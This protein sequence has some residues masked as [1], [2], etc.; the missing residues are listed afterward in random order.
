MM[1]CDDPSAAIVK[2]F[3]SSL[4]WFFGQIRPIFAITILSLIG[5][6]LYTI[7]LLDFSSE[8]Q[9][10]FGHSGHAKPLPFTPHASSIALVSVEWKPTFWSKCSENTGILTKN[11]RFIGYSRH[12]PILETAH[13]FFYAWPRPII[14]NFLDAPRGDSAF[15][16]PC[17][18]SSRY[19]WGHF[20]LSVSV[21]HGVAFEMAHSLMP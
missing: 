1:V 7:L 10:A 2:L 20:L 15:S 12:F 18:L 9:M 17:S 6:L 5:E 3:F 4:S 19:D 11:L 14:A 8:S 13:P 21:I 16:G